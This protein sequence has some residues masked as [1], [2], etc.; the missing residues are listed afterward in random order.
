MKNNFVPCWRGTKVYEGGFTK[1]RAD[2]GN[3]TGGKVG[4]GVLKGTNMG[5]SAAAFPTLDIEHLTEAQAMAIY[6]S[7]YWDAVRGDD[8]PAGV[9]NTTWD[10]GVNS[11]PS[12]SIRDLQRSAG[13][14]ADGKLGSLTL[15]AVAKADAVKL[16]KDHCARRL[17]FMQSLK[18]WNTFRSG[19]SKRVAA[20]EAASVAMYL[21]ATKSP[22]EA[23]AALLGEAGAAAGKAEKQ[24]A[25]AGRVGA[26]AVVTVPAAT[27]Q[28]GHAWELVALG[29]V[30][31][32]FVAC[33][34][35]A[36][37]H[38][39]ARADAYREAAANV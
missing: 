38:S 16:I 36:R 13:V 31:V 6:Q 19:W 39:A 4:V 5:V 10:Y 25:V 7:K 30:L 26:G 32:F 3:W 34:I 15:A 2:P 8:L 24:S 23:K 35:V 37:H 1:N 21:A 18:V 20:V 29:V 17:G 33:V 22:A 12:R 9:D 14:P 28:S 27:A 11:G